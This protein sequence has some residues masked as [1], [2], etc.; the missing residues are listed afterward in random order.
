MN[1]SRMDGIASSPVRPPV[2][3]LRSQ[4]AS[5]RDLRAR[6]IGRSSGPIRHPG[7]Q[8]RTQRVRVSAMR[9]RVSCT[10]VRVNTQLVRLSGNRAMK[11]GSAPRSIRNTGSPQRTPRASDSLMTDRKD[12]SETRSFHRSRSHDRTQRARLCA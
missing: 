3:F 5:E 9:I 7:I 4:S 1:H 11:I 6:T 10:R 2:T 12:G 8:V